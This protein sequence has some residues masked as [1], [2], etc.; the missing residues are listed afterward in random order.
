MVCEIIGGF[1]LV[2]YSRHKIAFICSQAFLIGACAHHVQ[3]QT[4]ESAQHKHFALRNVTQVASECDGVGWTDHVTPKQQQVI[5]QV[6][7]ERS[8]RLHHAL[9]H[10]VRGGLD[11]NQAT[12][13]KKAFGPSWVEFHPLCPSPQQDAD[14][15]SYNPAGE[16][17]LYMHREMIGMLRKKL[18][19]AK[20]ECISGWR[21]LRISGSA[22]R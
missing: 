19:E 16:D 13:V 8:H 4:D 21:N 1:S 20:L 3:N 2:A 6:M 12:D 11:K 9:W 18:I 15:E 5:N 22:G 7:K 10:A 14:K 17:F